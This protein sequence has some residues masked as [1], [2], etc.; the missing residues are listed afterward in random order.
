MN[1]DLH[2]PRG[3]LPSHSVLVLAC[4]A[5]MSAPAWSLGVGRPQAASSLGQPLNLLFPVQLSAGET[6]STDCVRAEVIAGDNP[7]STAGLHWQL[8]GDG[9]RVTGVRLRSLQRIDEPIVSVQLSLGCP[10]RLTRQYTAF[11]D[12]PGLNAEPT[13]ESGVAVAPPVSPALQAMQEGQPV[14]ANRVAPAASRATPDLAV[15]AATMPAGLTAA[16]ATPAASAST[17][18]A[19]PNRR[20]SDATPGPVTTTAAAMPAKRD[21]RADR[22]AA[23]PRLSME[24]AEV[25]A[26]PSAALL[27]A[28]AAASA[29][30]AAEQAQQ[31]VLAMQKQIADMQ[32]EQKRSLAALSALRQDLQAARDQA[33]RGGSSSSAWVLGL[34]LL[35]LALA[36]SSL[37]LW[38]GNRSRRRDAEQHWLRDSH[39]DPRE[40]A[41]AAA[42]SAQPPAT[43]PS[44]F[45]PTDPQSSPTPLMSH[46]TP[47]LPLVAAA[48]T[49]IPM[50]LSVAEPTR[51]AVLA[52]RATPPVRPPTTAADDALQALAAL[53]A[54]EPLSFQLDATQDTRPAPFSSDLGGSGGVV[55]VEEL[56]DLEQQVDFF[57][58]LGQDDAAIELLSSRLNQRDAA[59]GLPFL[60]LMELYQRRGDRE[61]FDRVGSRFAEQFRARAPSWSDDLNQGEGLE[62]HAELVDRLE[63]AWPDADGSM[64][65]LQDLLSKHQEY[66]GDLGLPAYRDLLLLYA[67]ARDRSEHEVGGDRIDVVLPLDATAPPDMMAT[68]VWQTPPPAPGAS[69]APARAAITQTVDLDLS[70]VE[71]DEP[72]SPKGR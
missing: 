43:G 57:M 26:A 72:R 62:A 30:S 55:T 21:T 39:L 68:M 41:P 6:V 38:R 35:S 32:A 3:T 45:T 17:R 54:M 52:P 64:S 63:A 71:E 61:A 53:E 42:D 5:V 56:I 49:T 9:Q 34:S 7:L 67:V 27:A 18:A 22:R 13:V 10:A 65:L 31:Q 12:P 60:K 16:A 66:S 29:A 20:R 59:S 14:A 33:A 25:L 70:L 47:D 8:E 15:A 51:P 19:R 48:P 1:R 46:L 23:T 4:L 24:A 36:T 28:E 69:P 44:P 37:L 2:D 11:I 40:A 58:V 50:P